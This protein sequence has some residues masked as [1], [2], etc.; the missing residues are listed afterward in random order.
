MTTILYL[1]GKIDQIETLLEYIGAT[2]WLVFN[3]LVEHESRTIQTR[4]I[5]ARWIVRS[6]PFGGV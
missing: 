3:A 4:H 1:V 5:R 6:R 2:I